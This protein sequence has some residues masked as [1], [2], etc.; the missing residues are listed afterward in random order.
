MI[1]AMTLPLART[2]LLRV[3]RRDLVLGGDEDLRLDLTIVDT[4]AADATPV[5]LS[6]VGTTLQMLIWHGSTW[7][8]YGMPHIDGRR[9]L[10]TATATLTDA[11]NGRAVVTVAR[12][13]GREWPQRVGYT[14]YLDLGGTARTSI[15]WGALHVPG[16]CG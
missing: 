6:P 15:G 2:S 14:L 16:G 3:S 4:D 7:R 10:H 11:L 9:T 13:A 12:N 5:D 8:D 1:L